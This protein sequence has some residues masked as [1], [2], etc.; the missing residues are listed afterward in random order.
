MENIMATIV[1]DIGGTAIKS[2]LYTNGE[3]SEIREIPT[4]AKQGRDHVL[5]RVK[6]LIADYRKICSFQRI[7]ISTAGQVNP[8]RGD[9]IYANENLPGYTGTPLKEIMEQ[10]FRVPTAVE[11]DVNAAA[12][13]EAVFGA[14]KGISDFACLTYGTG[15]GGAI[16]LNGNLTPEAAFPPENSAP[17]SLILKTVI[18][19]KTCFPDATKNML[20]PPLWSVWLLPWILP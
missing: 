4:E 1:L 5:N 2:G 15:V 11:N 10:E 8:L 6:E 20:P 13:G 9:I 7:G 19:N 16:F 3:L 14:G 12:I 17:S 18:L